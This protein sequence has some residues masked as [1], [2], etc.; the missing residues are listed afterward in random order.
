M[1]TLTPARGGYASERLAAAY[2]E[3]LDRLGAIPGVRS[4]TLSG[5][6]PISGAAASRYATVEGSTEGA[7]PRVFVNWVAP[8]YFETYGT[9]LLAGRDFTFQDQAASHAAIVNQSMAR[10]YFGDANPLGR[11]VTLERDD[12]PFE[13]VGVVADAKYL[14]L[15]EPAPRT[16][17]LCAFTEKGVIS[18]SFAIRADGDPAA[19]AGDVRRAMRAVLKDVPVENTI[20]L[21]AQMDASI[22]PERLIATLS[23]LFGALG[24]LLAPSDSTDCW[25]T[26]WHAGRT[27]SVSAWRWARPAVM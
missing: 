1:A 13:I 17:Y 7:E 6:T 15:H 22:V 24:L 23:T 8:R 20:T 25:R 11:H 19:V 26:P 4:A 16:V 27:K 12:R 2:R 10:H 18:H 21:A 9:P 5:A 14:D 3:L